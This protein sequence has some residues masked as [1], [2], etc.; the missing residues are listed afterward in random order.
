VTGGAG[1]IGK[2]LV[3]RILETDKFNRVIVIDNLCNSSWNDFAQFLVKNQLNNS[4]SSMS[5]KSNRSIDTSRIIFYKVD[6]SNSDEVDGVLEAERDTNIMACIHLAAKISVAK[7]ELCPQKTKNVNIHGTANVIKCAGRKDIPHFVFASSAAVYGIPSNLPIS[8][9]DPPRPISQYGMSKLDAERIVASYSEK[10]RTAISLRLFNVYGIGQT[11]EYTGVITRFADRIKRNL[12][13]EIHGNGL[14]TRDFI[15]IDDVVDAIMRASRLVD[16]EG[17]VMGRSPRPPRDILID[18]DS[19][20]RVYNI[21]TGVPTKII[22]LAHMMTEILVH[23]GSDKLDLGPIYVV[24]ADGD[25]DE[26]YANI[27]KARIGLGFAPT[28][29]LRRGLENMLIQ[30]KHPVY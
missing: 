8:E 22:D 28:I 9:S 30:K 23:D 10:N 13:P 16:R 25:I 17:T 26:S 18:R 7:C 19:K 4:F 24:R 20:S 15:H 12:A 5:G 2:N 11:M 1:F 14:Q 29:D 21:G 3:K 6:I 27:R